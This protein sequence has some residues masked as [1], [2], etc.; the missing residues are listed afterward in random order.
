VECVFDDGSVSQR[1]AKQAAAS[2]KGEKNIC[3]PTHLSIHLNLAPMHNVEI[4]Q[5][6]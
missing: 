2:D 6:G 1:Q 5:G 4:L 3:T